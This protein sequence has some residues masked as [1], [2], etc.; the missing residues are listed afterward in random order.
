MV[1]VENRTD[2]KFRER[3]PVI[4]NVDICDYRLSISSTTIHF[5]DISQNLECIYLEVRSLKAIVFV[6]LLVRKDCEKKAITSVANTIK[7]MTPH[8]STRLDLATQS[9]PSVSKC[10][11]NVSSL[12]PAVVG[13]C[14]L[15][16]S[17]MRLRCCGSKLCS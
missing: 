4:D 10:S 13:F 1:V 16:I 15:D 8:G 2:R 12:L 11:Q 3:K 9:K 5:C 7:Q 17:G 6:G 14:F